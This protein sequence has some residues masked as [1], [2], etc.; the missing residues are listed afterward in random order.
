M[1]ITGIRLLLRWFA[2]E[3]MRFFI[4]RLEKKASQSFYGPGETYQKNNESEPTIAY[5]P[6]RRKKS[7]KKVGEYIEYE[8]ID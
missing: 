2:P 6:P 7:N 3:I 4:K 5:E 8:E 1:V